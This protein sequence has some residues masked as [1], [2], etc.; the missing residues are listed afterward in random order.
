MKIDAL[1]FEVALYEREVRI[2]SV[3]AEGNLLCCVVRT[4]ILWM[5][6]IYLEGDFTLA[7]LFRC[8][9]GFAAQEN[10]QCDQDDQCST[11]D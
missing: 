6:I 3:C 10:D 1:I 5:R 2:H 8:S 7:I 11:T 4:P 9:V